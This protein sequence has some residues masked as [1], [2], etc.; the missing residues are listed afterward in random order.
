MALKMLA[1]VIL[2][3]ADVGWCLNCAPVGEKN[4]GC[5]EILRIFYGCVLLELAQLLI[6]KKDF[7]C[8]PC[9][10]LAQDEIEAFLCN[11]GL[12]Y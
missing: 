1:I 10:T 8:L 6:S 4:E 2:E 7:W 12:P 3:I 5:G 11:G 9:Y